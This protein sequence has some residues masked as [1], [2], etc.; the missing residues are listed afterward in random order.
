MAENESPQDK[1]AQEILSGSPIVAEARQALGKMFQTTFAV[2]TEDL[3]TRIKSN[4]KP[5]K[6][7]A[8][9]DNLTLDMIKLLRKRVETALA[10]V[11]DD[12]TPP[13]E[14]KP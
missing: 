12:T 11:T 10:A 8:A 3:E 9:V 5:D 13:P 4:A 2:L 6:M 14:T 1:L 7:A